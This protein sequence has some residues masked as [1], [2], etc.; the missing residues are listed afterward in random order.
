MKYWGERGQCWGTVFWYF[1]DSFAEKFY[2]T[3]VA[4]NTLRTVPD[5]PIVHVSPK[6]FTRSTQTQPWLRVYL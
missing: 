2:T 1:R 3:N 4:I 6:G 5:L